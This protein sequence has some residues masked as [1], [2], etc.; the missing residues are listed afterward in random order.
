ME[1]RKNL[2]RLV[3]EIKKVSNLKGRTYDEFVTNII[4]NYTNMCNENANMKILDD[5]NYEQFV[6]VKEANNNLK[7][8]CKLYAKEAKEM[9][10]TINNLT[11]TIN[12]CNFM[13]RQS[14]QEIKTY[15]NSIAS[16]ECLIKGYNKKT[17]DHLKIINNYSKKEL[18]YS[19]EISELKEELDNLRRQ[20]DTHSE[21]VQNASIRYVNALIGR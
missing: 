21:N 6:E 5:I 3:T 9:R 7:R 11:D 2:N 4:I 15:K 14:E 1:D 8:V 17:E 12:T 16:Y 20:F 19:R 10:E 18:G 13:Y